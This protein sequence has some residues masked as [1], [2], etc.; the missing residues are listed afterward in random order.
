MKK[1][2][3][4]L[5]SIVIGI[6]LSTSI[7]A[8]SSDWL[9]LKSAGGDGDDWGISTAVDAKGNCFILGIFSSPSITFGR[10]TLI[11]KSNY[12]DEYDIFLVKYDP[13]GNVLWAKSAGGSNRDI[14]NSI[15][16]DADGNC[17]ITGTF[18]S[19][20]ILFSPRMLIKWGAYSNAFIVKYDP[21]GNVLWAKAP[22]NPSD[23]YG[24]SVTTDANGN[25]FVTGIF[26]NS[27]V[28]FDSD[29]LKNTGSN[30]IYFVKYDPNGNVI[31][32]KSIGGE[33]DSYSHS[34]ATDINGNCFITGTFDG[35]FITF[36]SRTS[37]SGSGNSD[38]FIAK[39]DPNGNVLW[40]K[41]AGGIGFDASYSV[42][43]DVNGNCFVTGSFYSTSIT[44]DFFKLSNKGGS[45][46]FLVKYNPNGNVLWAK[47][48]GES[49]N[50]YS[51]SAAVDING[52]CFITGY[53]DG[54]SITFGS[55]TITNIGGED[56]FLAKY[57]PKGNVLLA[58]FA[59]NCLLNDCGNSVATDANGNC[60]ITGYFKS[61][62][63]AFGSHTVT[64]S[65]FNATYGDVFLAKLNNVTN[66]VDEKSFLFDNITVYPNPNSGVFTLNFTTQQTGKAEINI[67]DI[68]G[69]IVYS[70]KYFTFQNENIKE[71]NV[72][73]ITSGAY[74]LRVKINEKVYDC[75]LQIK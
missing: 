17:F 30:N 13:N 70:E 12:Q 10:N 64:N 20:S 61:P 63:I 4:I 58:K 6:F 16:I 62:F 65:T 24:E 41:S 7:F 38:I 9:W 8:Q 34:I 27:S 56:I 71:I 54:P 59:T 50:N 49:G 72:G 40:A 15:A 37:V 53:F 75:K 55:Y 5:V 18:E 3:V 28:A 22:G 35:S 36:D 66:S 57:D 25:C 32:T 43:T 31:W 26:E 48:V 74:I 69:K 29:T 33:F 60:Y 46:I 52:N 21:D 42:A 1:L 73:K 67:L 47:S 39:Y 11:N 68:L 45:N 23:N 19:P 2:F 14:G 44:F 51:Y